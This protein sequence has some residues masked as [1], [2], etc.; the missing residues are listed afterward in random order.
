MPVIFK[1]LKAAITG[2]PETQELTE[3]QKKALIDAGLME[4]TAKPY[5]CQGAADPS[6][7][8]STSYTVGGRAVIVNDLYTWVKAWKPGVQGTVVRIFPPRADCGPFDFGLLE[9][10]LDGQESPVYFRAWEVRPI[11]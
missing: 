9:L 10:K 4:A 3:R 1:R 7:V 5:T 8:L 11:P 2:T 6:T